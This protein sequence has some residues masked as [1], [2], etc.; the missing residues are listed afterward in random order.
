MQNIRT[1]KGLLSRK[2]GE[3]ATFKLRR[4]GSSVEKNRGWFSRERKRERGG[5]KNLECDGLI[6]WKRMQK[7][8]EHC[9]NC[10]FLSGKTN[11]VYTFRRLSHSDPRKKR[12]SHCKRLQ[13]LFLACGLYVN[14]LLSPQ[15]RMLSRVP[16][17]VL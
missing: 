8:E 3:H 15:M 5:R 4:I 6:G 10:T 7:T 2:K 1:T 11:M 9:E 16:K 12:V 13:Y 17:S 14:V